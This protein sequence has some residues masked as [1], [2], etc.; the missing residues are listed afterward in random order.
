MTRSRRSA[1]K[2]VRDSRDRSRPHWPRPRRRPF[3]R[4]HATAPR[5][6]ATSAACGCTVTGLFSMQRHRRLAF[7]LDRRAQP[8]PATMT[9]WSA[10]WCTS[11]A[12]WAT[13]CGSGWF[14]RRRPCRDPHRTAGRAIKRIT[15][16]RCTDGASERWR[17]VPGF[18]GLYQISAAGLVRSVDRRVAQGSRWGRR[19]TNTHRGR[20]LTPFVTPNGRKR[21]V[22]HDESHRRHARYLDELVAETFG[23]AV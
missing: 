14:H 2:P 6:A 21:V 20:V 4:R 22:L 15:L 9:R 16:D 19:L 7:R 18:E 17:D 8:R 1:K 10:W 12:G 13:R 5:T 3:E 11:A 23:G